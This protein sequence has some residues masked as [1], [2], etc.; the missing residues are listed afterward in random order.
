MGY[1]AR[2]QSDLL[3][4][5][6]R[7]EIFKFLNDANEGG[8]GQLHSKIGFTKLKILVQGINGYRLIE[9][10][11]ST[12]VN[13]RNQPAVITASPTPRGGMR[14]AFVKAFGTGFRI[15]K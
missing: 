13:A 11:A 3:H 7:N 12:S 10:E 2:A 15:A 4:K 5:S 9:L 14:F 6:G 8:D 1:C